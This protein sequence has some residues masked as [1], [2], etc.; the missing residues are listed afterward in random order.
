MTLQIIIKIH[1]EEL[2]LS[3]LN[4]QHLYYVRFYW[5]FK[6]QHLFVSVSHHFG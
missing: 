6:T 2:Y 4:V 3:F 1:V 5:Y